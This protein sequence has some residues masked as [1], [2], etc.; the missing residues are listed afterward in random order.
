MITID[1]GL[2]KI[3]YDNDNGIPTVSERELWKALEVETPYHKWFPRMCEYGFTEGKDF[4]T[5]LSKSTGGRPAADHQLTIL[6]AKE[7]CMIQRNEIGKNVVNI[8]SKLKMLGII[9]R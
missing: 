2:I 6:M 4:W 7:L 5:F 8:L 1:T 9:Q 3:N